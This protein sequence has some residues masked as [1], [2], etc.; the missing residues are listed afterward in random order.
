MGFLD[1]LGG[2]TEG[3]QEMLARRMLE[4]KMAQEQQQQELDNQL[5]QRQVEQA[6][7]RLGQDDREF[8]LRQN[9]FGLEQMLAN[10]PAPPEK[11]IAMGA[12]QH[13]VDPTQGRIIMQTPPAERP[14]ERPISLA[15]GG[16]L[17]EPSTGRI[18][19]SM[20]DRPQQQP[21]SMGDELAEYEAKKK[22]DAQYKAGDTAAGPSD[23]A[24]TTAERTIKAVDEVLPKIGITTA[25]P[26]GAIASYLPGTEAANV[27]ADLSSV[28]SN[29]A[30]NALQAMREASKTGG[31]L[32]QVSERELDLL[33]GVEGSIRQNQSP[34]NLKKNLLLIK[35]SQ[36]R[37]L[38]AARGSAPSQGAGSGSAQQRPIPGIPGGGAELRNGKWIRV[39]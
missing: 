12:G 8:G 13:L 1:V 30:F 16:S 35:E 38:A 21:R 25:G 29:V 34:A 37:W 6:D 26:M 7:R 24:I 5:R 15:P 28:A 3:L 31:A 2:A 11:P 19:R 20:P 14:P 22:I 27:S 10:R 36:M 23:Y 39:K 4:Q 17:I 18:I 33:S 9:Q 32:G